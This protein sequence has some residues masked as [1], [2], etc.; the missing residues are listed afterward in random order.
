MAFGRF[1]SRLGWTGRIGGAAIVA[2]LAMGSVVS[3][4]AT[5]GA[6][7]PTSLRAAVASGP[8][9]GPNV[10]VFDPSMTRSE[11]QAKVDAVAA[12]QLTNQF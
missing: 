6:A 2:L 7:S 10:L 8:D 1:V 3:T 5:A 11:I 4:A 12:Q 9:F